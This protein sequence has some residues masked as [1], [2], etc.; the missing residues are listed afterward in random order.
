MR[1]I[2]TQNLVFRM[3][4][5]KSMPPNKTI[6]CLHSHCTEKK[7]KEKRLASFHSGFTAEQHSTTPESCPCGQ[8]K[9]WLLTCTS[10]TLFGLVSA[11]GRFLG[12]SCFSSTLQHGFACFLTSYSHSNYGRFSNLSILVNLEEWINFY[13]PDSP[14]WLCVMCKVSTHLCS[15]L[16]KHHEI[17]T[18][19]GKFRNRRIRK[20][21]ELLSVGLCSCMTQ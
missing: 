10:G 8:Q 9:S 3:S 14:V 20:S 2:V 12:A 11:A 15:S 21:K 5:S 1:K 16:P 7:E 13:L 19:G 6:F 17:L 18:E 4:Q